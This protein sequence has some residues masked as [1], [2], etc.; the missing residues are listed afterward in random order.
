[1]LRDDWEFEYTTEQLADAAEAQR[2][3]RAARVMAWEEKKAEVIQRIKESGIDV[4]DSIANA[5]GNMPAGKYVGTQSYRGAHITIN[6]EMQ[7]DL[8]EC[9]EKIREHTNLRNQ[10]AAWVQILQGN[11]GKTLKLHHDDWMFFFG[12]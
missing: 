9:V 6:V 12:K 1:M 8:N 4:S 5:M 2:A 10:Y 7:E 3:F 11:P